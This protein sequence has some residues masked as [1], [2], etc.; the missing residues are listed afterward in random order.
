V[1]IVGGII[2]SYAFDAIAGEKMGTT[3]EGMLESAKGLPFENFGSQKGPCLPT[4]GMGC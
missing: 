2:A 3:A 4:Y 1:S